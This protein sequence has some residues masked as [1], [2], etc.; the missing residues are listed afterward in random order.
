MSLCL[1]AVI[2]IEGDQEWIKNQL[3]N[4][5]IDVPMGIIENQ[6]F[7][8]LVKDKSIIVECNIPLNKSKLDDK[9]FDETF[10]REVVEPLLYRDEFR[11]RIHDI[12]IC[13]QIA[14]P[15]C[16]NFKEISLYS[17][18]R[19][20]PMSFY[21]SLHA[22][23]VLEI[24]EEPFY[25][26]Y[27]TL[28]FTVVWEWLKKRQE[29]WVEVPRT[30]FGRFLNYVR[31]IYYDFG[32]LSPLWLSM[33]LESLLVENQSFAKSQMTGKLYELLKSNFSREEIKAYVSKFY[34]L[35]SK[36]AH[37]NLNL[38]RPTLIHNAT[39]EVED[40]DNELIS[41]NS[42]GIFSVIYCLQF[43]IENNLE[44]FEFKEDIIYTIKI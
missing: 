41:N 44:H 11:V 42:F 17:N 13:L 5:K 34:K 39:K 10:T 25:R 29:F 22:P 24:Y 40:I 7:E 36:I 23:F 14:K 8:F 35:R 15:N 9:E 30:N 1:E 12:F 3:H 28:D 6:E 19:E 27:K 21:N 20:I 31:Y 38:Y 33:A 18:K 4:V 37:G 26:M 2:Q 43:M 16:V 32:V